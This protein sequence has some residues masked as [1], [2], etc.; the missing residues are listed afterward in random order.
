MKLSTKERQ[1]LEEASKV[2]TKIHSRFG[3]KDFCEN[4]SGVFDSFDIEEASTL[5]DLLSRHESIEFVNDFDWDSN[6]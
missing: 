2:L 6:K 3:R 1:T 5:C 4:K